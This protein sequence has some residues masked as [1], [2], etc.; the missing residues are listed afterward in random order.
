M[1]GCVPD[2][3]RAEKPCEFR[4]WTGVRNPPSDGALT[5][6]RTTP[7]WR[8]AVHIGEGD[9][10]DFLRARREKRYALIINDPKPVES[11]DDIWAYSAQFA[12]IGIFVLLLGAA[13]YLCRPLL[14]PILAAV[15]I[16]MTLGPLVKRAA[17]AGF[18]P[19]ATAL[20]LGVLLV[21]LAGLAVTL[22]ASPVTEWIGKAPDIGAAL[23]QKL[24]VFERPL[25]ALRE[26]QDVLMPSAPNSVSVETSQLSMVTPVVAFVTPAV[27]QFMLFFV[28]LIF[29]LAS[30][31]SLRR[32]IASFFTSRDGKLR[33]IR[34]AN[35]IEH[36]LASYVATVTVI[37]LSL[38]AVVA[39][40]AWLFGF[41]GPATFGILAMLLNYIPYIGPAAMTAVLFGVGLISFPSL[42]FALLPPAAFVALTTIEGQII[43]PAVLGRRLTLNP[44]AVLFSLA[45][46][47]W[48]WGPMGAFL[49]VPIAI[50]ALVTINHLFPG[51][52]IKLPG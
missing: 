19:W 9:D 30:Q 41:P 21:A 18:P 1:A 38:G 25:A 3:S 11:T 12:T 47:A 24:F 33:F 27:V 4:D 16:G 49:A 5:T 37:N 40:G 44:L 39:L 50:V 26:L 7:G 13:L 34:I 20:V 17:K 15:L 10:L 43:T 32:Y 22:L 36:N 46:W 52:D 14:L 2:R 29:F 48:L 45:F 6:R 51:E 23:K 28:T 8:L 35:D 42:G 31:V